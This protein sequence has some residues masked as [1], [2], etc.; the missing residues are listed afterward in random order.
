ML[1]GR[2]G[3]E[4]GA[5]PPIDEGPGIGGVLQGRADR[6]D[7]RPAPGDVPEV[8]LAGDQEA[9]VVE[10]P[11]DPSGRPDPEE[12]LEDE[13]DPALDLD[14]GVLD[15]PVQG[16]SDQADGQGQGQFAAAG[17]VEE[18][19][20]ESASDRMQFQFRDLALQP[21]E[22]APV[23]RGRVVDPVAIGDEAIAEAAD[24][25]QRIPVRAVAREPGDFG[26]EDNSYMFECNEGHELLKAV[27]SL[28]RAGGP[29]LILVDDP[30]LVLVPAEFE[31][32]LLEGILEPGDSPGWS[33]LGGGWTGGCR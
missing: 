3:L 17:L 2:A 9:I 8:I 12:G 16:V 21:E 27:T 29:A 31:G 1:V 15:D 30:D 5:R 10:G 14:V 20:G 22:E 26:G 18:A 23:D 7:R 25:E 11:H 13:G 24:V 19:G 28:G 32:A 33:G 6:G 4:H